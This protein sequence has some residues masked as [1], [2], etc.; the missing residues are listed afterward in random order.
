MN[1]KIL[2]LA[3]TFILASC[4]QMNDSLKSVNSGLADFNSALSGKSVLAVDQ[5]TKEHTAQAISSAAPPKN[6]SQL[7]KESSTDLSNFLNAMACGKDTKIYAD[8][9]SIVLPSPLSHMREH[10]SSRGCLQVIR[11]DDISMKTAITYEFRVIFLSPQSEESSKRY[12]VAVKQPSGDFLFR[13]V[14]GK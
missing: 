13:G 11:V 2:L 9:K 4:Q 12:Y 3:S 14:I 10:N 5:S 6:A 1:K 8:A 7:F